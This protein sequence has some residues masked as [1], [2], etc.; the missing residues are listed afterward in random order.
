MTEGVRESVVLRGF[1]R[2]YLHGNHMRRAR[3][4]AVQEWRERGGRWEGEGDDGEEMAAV[5]VVVVVTIGAARF[6]YRG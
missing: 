4:S 1:C 6:V 2:P 3:A 5:V